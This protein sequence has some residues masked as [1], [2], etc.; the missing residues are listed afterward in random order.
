MTTGNALPG[1][2]VLNW[3]NSAGDAS[4]WAGSVGTNVGV[5]TC[6]TVTHTDVDVAVDAGEKAL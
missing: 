6:G 3:M 5:V 4:T 2:A 1:G